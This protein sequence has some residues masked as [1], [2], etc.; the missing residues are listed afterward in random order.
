MLPANH[1]AHLCEYFTRP[2]HSRVLR[3]LRIPMRVCIISPMTNDTSHKN[4]KRSLDSIYTDQVQALDARQ[5]ALNNER[6]EL[7]E[8]YRRGLRLLERTH[9]ESSGGETLFPEE[10]RRDS[11]T[12]PQE[13]VSQANGSSDTPPWGKGSMTEEVRIVLDEIG[14]DEVFTQPIIR[15]KFVEKYPGSNSVSLQTS[16][17]HLL[18]QLNKRGELDR[19]GKESPTDPYLYCKTPKYRNRQERE[20]ARLLGP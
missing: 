8:W 15:T 13:R 10:S 16:I 12:A 18:R 5:Q 1:I 2:M 3:R 11:V 14:A 17:S 6:N 9:S 7:E 4:L 19:F 20:E